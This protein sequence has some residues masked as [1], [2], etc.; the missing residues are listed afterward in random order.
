M[1]GRQ[2]W[3]PTKHPSVWPLPEAPLGASGR[4]LVEYLLENIIN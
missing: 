4:T 2:R 1:P 3:T